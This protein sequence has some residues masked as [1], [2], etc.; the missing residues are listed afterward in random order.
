MPRL[1]VAGVVRAFASALDCAAGAIVGVVALP[2]SILKADF[3]KVRKHLN[4][5]SMAP[6]RAAKIQTEF[7]GR[8]E[9][10]I[11]AAGPEGWLDWTLD[12]RNMLVH[13]GRRLEHGQ[14]VPRMPFLYGHDA[15]PLVRI[16]KVTHLPRD[17]ARSDVEVSLDPLHTLVLSEDVEQTLTGLLTST[18]T[19]IDMIGRELCEVWNWR[20]ENPRSPCQPKEQW[21]NGRSIA[22]S[23]FLGYAPGTFELDPSMAVVHPEVAHRFRSAA[24]DDAHWMMPRARSGLHSIDLQ[25]RSR[26]SQCGDISYY[27]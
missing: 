27:R 13:R 2:M 7:G 10:L 1:H 16:R 15:Q 18:M 12:F 20:R 4:K 5:S 14:F 3:R 6:K 8:L 23:T 9:D 19:L 21:P 26:V 17:P 22:S 24:L 11:A 25:I